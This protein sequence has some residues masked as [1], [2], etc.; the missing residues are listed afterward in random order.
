MHKEP[1]IAAVIVAAGMGSRMNARI[2]KQYLRLGDKT[3]LGRTLEAFEACGAIEEI[4]VAVNENE[5]ELCRQEVLAPGDFRKVRL[6][7]GGETRQASVYQGLLALSA[8]V[9]LVL[10]HDGARPL[11][12]QD[13]LQRCITETMKHGATVVAVPVKNTIK[14]GDGSGL[15]G[16]TLD[17]SVLY[18]VQTPQSFALPLILEAHRQAAEEGFEA[19]DDS[20]LVEHIGQPVHIVAGRYQNVKIT[21]PEDLV[22]TWALM[23]S[24]E[25]GH[26]LRGF[27]NQQAGRT[28][29]H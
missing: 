24:A 22:T 13:T 7:T 11:I 1:K 5:H 9:D 25:N 12:D 18:E 19:T 17:R 14:T 3:I 27:L 6:T 23:D 15:V 16:E 8:D 4:V 2:N 21:T 29:S 20:M 10:I 26:N 28:G